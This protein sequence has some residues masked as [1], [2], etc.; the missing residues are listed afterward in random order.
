MT[1]RTQNQVENVMSSKALVDWFDRDL[2]A[3][4][5]GENKVVVYMMMLNKCGEAIHG[6]RDV[7]GTVIKLSIC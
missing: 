1:K 4:Q 5:M 2:F 7:I 6:S 3:Y